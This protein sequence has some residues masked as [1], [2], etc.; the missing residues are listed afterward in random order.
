MIVSTRYWFTPL[1][2]CSARAF[3]YSS[4]KKKRARKGLP[5]ITAKEGASIR[6]FDALHEPLRFTLEY[7]AEIIEEVISKDE[8]N[9]TIYLKVNCNGESWEH[10]LCDET[11]NENRK[12]WEFS[13]LGDTLDILKAKLPALLIDRAAEA[14][15]DAYDEAFT[16]NHYFPP[17]TASDWSFKKLYNA[18]DRAYI[19]ALH[20]RPRETVTLKT[21][22]RFIT[23]EYLLRPPLTADG[24]RMLIKRYGEKE[25]RGTWRQLKKE[26]EERLARYKEGL[27]A[28]N[29]RARKKTRSVSASKGKK[30]QLRA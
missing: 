26:F 11:Q 27:I 28:K 3:L 12:F 24:L 23:L 22:A 8:T 14:F 19:A 2:N 17:R 6:V 29:E 30:E 10:V 16:D 4:M 7:Q 18:L 1:P 21:L 25:G 5:P 15:P 9:V 13:L 20:K